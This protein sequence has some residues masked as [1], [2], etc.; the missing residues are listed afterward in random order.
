[1]EK[2]QGKIKDKSGSLEIKAVWQS[3][4]A[5]FSFFTPA[6]VSHDTAVQAP[7]L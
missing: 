2:Y 5:V 3:K 4:K 7:R 1:M 6:L